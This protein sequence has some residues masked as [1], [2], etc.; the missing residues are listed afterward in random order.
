MEKPNT[1]DETSIVDRQIKKV[2]NE[3]MKLVALAEAGLYFS[4][5][6]RSAVY[7]IAVEKLAPLEW[8]DVEFE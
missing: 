6:Q 3:T 2:L 1:P 5:G 4:R 8:H 7:K